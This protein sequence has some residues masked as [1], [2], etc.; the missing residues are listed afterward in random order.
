[1]SIYKT[2]NGETHPLT[3]FLPQ[4]AKVLILGSFPPP[5]KR[6]CMEFFYPNWTNDFWRIWGYIAQG[7][8]DYF[9]VPGEKRFDKEKIVAFCQA[10]GLALYDT[11]EEIVRLKDNASDNFLQVIRPTDIARLLEM[12]PECHAIVATGQKSAD[13]LASVLGCAPL[14]VGECVETQCAGRAVK[15]WRMPSTSRAYPRSV[16]WKAEYYK[17][18]FSDLYSTHSPQNSLL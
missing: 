8:K 13:T 18:I 3:P 15:V 1:M 9:V 7:D 14:S 16:E 10:Y 5:R 17:R 12:L 11:A 6:W 2:M 4:G